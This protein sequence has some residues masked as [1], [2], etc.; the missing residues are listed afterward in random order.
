MI[1]FLV[2]KSPWRSAIEI[3]IAE[4]D[5]EGELMAVARSVT[6]EKLTREEH[7]DQFDPTLRL[8]TRAVQSLMDDLWRAGVRPSNGEG[9]VGQLAATEKHLEDMRKLVFERPMMLAAATIQAR[10]HG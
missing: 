3:L 5:F 6:L 2:H 8:E 9:N 1:E 10:D 7:G 4:R